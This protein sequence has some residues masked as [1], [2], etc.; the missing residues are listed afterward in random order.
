MMRFRTYYPRVKN[1]SVGVPGLSDGV[2]N[3]SNA[4]PNPNVGVKNLSVGVINLSLGKIDL[5]PIQF[6]QFLI[7]IPGKMGKP[8]TISL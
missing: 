6:L 2:K 1:L 3:L 7:L 8:G 5:A 4:V